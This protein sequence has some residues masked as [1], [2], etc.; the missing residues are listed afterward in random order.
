M[1]ETFSEKQ[2]RFIHDMTAE[3]RYQHRCMAYSYQDGPGLM[4]LA[5][6]FEGDRVLELGCALGYT[7]CC[8]AG[9]AEG[10]RV[11]TIEGDSLHVQI[12]RENIAKV[13]LEERITVHHGDFGQVMPK[14]PNDYDIAFFDGLSPTPAMLMELHRKLRSGGTLICANFDFAGS[15]CDKFLKDTSLWTMIGELERGGTQIVRKA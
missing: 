12:A 11:D 5:G 9:S 14:L 7:A 2:F 10:R 8:L 4:K 15:G 1:A 3:H 13:G 6:T